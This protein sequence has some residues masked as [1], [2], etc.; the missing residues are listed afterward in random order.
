MHH[1]VAIGFFLLTLFTPFFYYLCYGFTLDYGRWQIFAVASILVFIAQNYEEREEMPSWFFD[2]SLG[3]VL[4]GVIIAVS[5]ALG[6]QDKYPNQVY[7]LGDRIYVV[8]GQVIYIFVC[9]FYL[10]FRHNK[11]I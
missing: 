11:K 1:L 2:V 8:I 7:E 6:Y 9:Y 5:F 3:T 10:R 4:I